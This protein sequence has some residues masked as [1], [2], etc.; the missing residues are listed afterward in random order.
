MAVE[1]LSESATLIYSEILDQIRLVNATKPD[2]F[3]FSPKVR[4]GITS[5]YLQHAMGAQRKQLYIGREDHGALEKIKQQKE[6]WEQAKPNFRQLDRLTLMAIAG[7]CTSV[8]HRAFKVL[9]LFDQAG[10]FKAGCVLAGSYAFQ[11]Y[12]NML[13]ISWPSQ[14]TITHDVDLALD[15]CLLGVP[16]KLE[17][18]DERILISDYKLLAICA[19][20]PDIPCT[21]YQIR[22]KQFRIDVITNSPASE[23]PIFIP[24][25]KTY[26]NSVSFL[27]FILENTQK[28]ALINKSAVLV[29]VPCPARFALHNLVISS[30]RPR[31]ELVKARED[32]AQATLLIE[33]LLADR[34]GDLWRA[35]DDVKSYPSPA[36]GQTV[37]K[38]LSQLPDQQSTPL[39][40]YW[41]SV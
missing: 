20:N 33:V 4:G 18:L 24:K 1:Y 2:G 9:T 30:K 23:S 11:A 36:F 6:Q 21:T 37:L 5:W 3:S 40:E 31:S 22:G 13:G 19:L 41:D 26:A 39:L 32:V 35:I 8:S 25:L 15:S 7:G 17:P 34:P 28:V 16:S 14:S 12:A 29:N 10:L 38:A 27:D